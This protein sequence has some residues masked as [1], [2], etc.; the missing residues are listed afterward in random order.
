MDRVLPFLVMPS[1]ALALAAVVYFIARR[2][3][4]RVQPNKADTAASFEPLLLGAIPG[5]RSHLLG[6]LASMSSAALAAWIAN[7]RT[8]A[9]IQKNGERGQDGNPVL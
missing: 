6:M 5:R 9:D 2:D 1:G 8:H 4:R 3:A 7:F